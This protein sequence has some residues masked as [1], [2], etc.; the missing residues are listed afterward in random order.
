MTKHTRARRTL[1][2]SPAH[3]RGL[4]TCDKLR[5]GVYAE[6]SKGS[7]WFRT[8]MLPLI[9]RHRKAGDIVRFIQ[10]AW[11]VNGARLEVA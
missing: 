6:T 11:H 8:K 7:H 1:D 2:G 9:E 5:T 3:N 10:G 4:R